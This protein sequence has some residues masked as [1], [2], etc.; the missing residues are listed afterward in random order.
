MVNKT[1]WII[2]CDNC[3]KEYDIP[4]NAPARL[5]EVY[6]EKRLVLEFRPECPYCNT[7]NSRIAITRWTSI[8][9]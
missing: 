6:G 9:K 4:G 7:Y 5:E 3:Q 8:Q 2:K 1:A